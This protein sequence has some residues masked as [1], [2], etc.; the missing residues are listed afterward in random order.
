M[1]QL[2]EET[3]SKCFGGYQKVFSHESQQLKCKMNFGVY[4]PEFLFKSGNTEKANVVFFLSGLTCSEQNFI[5][6]SGFQRYANE[7]GLVVVNPDTS[8]RNC[9]VE[10]EDV[11]WDFGTGAGFYLDATTEN[12]KTNYR[13]YSYV[14]KELIPLVDQHF[15]NYVKQGVRAITGHSMGGHGALTIALKNP[16]LFKCAAAFSPISN[17]INCPWGDKAFTGYLG[18][19]KS[20]WVDYDATELVQKYNGPNLHI[21][22][23][24][25]SVDPYLELQLKVDNFVKAS[26][27]N[28]NLTVD[29]HLH[30]DYDHSFFFV[31]TFLSDHFKH[32][33]NVLNA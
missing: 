22:I 9:N 7:Y 29:Y 30:P 25:G 28:K 24:Q 19:D 32:I 16:T 6:K 12:F 3:S 26:S 4:L 5:I 23:D 11:D 18:S 2:K 10:G 33:V 21:R 27:T 13:M 8:P 17:P 15:N 14:V 1:A 20:T 31:G